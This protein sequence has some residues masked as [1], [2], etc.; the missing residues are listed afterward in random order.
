MLEIK[1]KLKIPRSAYKLEVKGRLHLPFAQRRGGDEPVRLESGEEVRIK[2]PRGEVLRGG[3]LATASDGRVIEV[4]AQPEK[5]LRAE[6]KSP[7][8]AAKAAYQLGSRH[9]PVEVGEGCLLVAASHELEEMLRKAGASL[10]ELQAPFEPEV[11]KG[12][13]GG[14]DYRHGH[15][16]DHHHH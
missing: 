11:D 10:S 14:H 7:A 12:H 15:D 5:L 9:V 13:A 16:H 8:E 2:L 6:F 4:I 3:D 1:A